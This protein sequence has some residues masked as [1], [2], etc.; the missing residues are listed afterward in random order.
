[1]YNKKYLGVLTI[2]FGI[3]F[4]LLFT[5]FWACS[6][7]IISPIMVEGDMDDPIFTAVRS[8][9]DDMVDSIIHNIHNP[10]TNPWGFPLDSS[11]LD[12]P[13][14]D[15]WWGPMNPNDS[16]DYDYS[17]GWHTMYV[18]HLTASGSEIYYDSMS[19][20]IDGRPLPND[21][22]GIDEIKY[23]GSYALDNSTASDDF[24]LEFITRADITDV[25]TYV[26]SAAGTGE[27][28]TTRSYSQ[29]GSDFTEELDFNITFSDVELTRNTLSDWDHYRRV[30]G[31][32]E[33]DLT[34]TVETT[35]G[36]DTNIMQQDWIIEIT[37]NGTIAEVKATYGNIQWTFD[38]N[39]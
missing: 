29:Y 16:A 21:F 18:V 39:L 3:G 2:L 23:R 33:S 35:N 11:D 34:Y 38:H 10:L 37:L 36:D 28:I 8:D 13:D 19:F 27:I 20:L 5:T 31:Q 6:S 9:V 24:T 17:D 22:A 32:I 25:D 7:D 14:S 30:D 12:D 15:I 4:V 26:A 1:M